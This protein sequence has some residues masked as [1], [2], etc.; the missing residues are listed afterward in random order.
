MPTAL[1][2]LVLPPRCAGCDASGA[3]V[4]ARCTAELHGE[5]ARRMPT[6]VPPG[7]PDC[8]SAT[9][10]TGAARRT[11]IAYKERGRT[12]LAPSLAGAL[13][14]TIATAVGD[15]PVVL[16]PVPSARSAVRR[17]G[18]D[19]VARLAELAAGCLRAAGW[20]VTVAGV[21]SQRRRVADQAGLSSLQRAANLSMAFRVATGRNGSAVRS[22]S[23]MGPVVLVDDI[24]TTGATLAEAA[25]ALG[26]AGVTVPFA[27][28]VAATRRKREVPPRYGG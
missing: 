24:I 15:R 3:L 19:P 25:R 4:C 11:I 17:R 7:L 14:L 9:G 6:P 10:Y 1:L 16:V 27:V 2:D 8:W 21:L 28:T 12:A 23:G 5:P 26:E 20:P 13:A 18:H 22:W